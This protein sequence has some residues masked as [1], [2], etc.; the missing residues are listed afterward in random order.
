[1][2]NYCENIMDFY[3]KDIHEVDKMKKLIEDTGVL[4]SNYM[5]E[6]KQYAEGSKEFWNWRANNWGTTPDPTDIEVCYSDSDP[7]EISLI[8]HTAWDSPTKFFDTM[9]DRGWGV[10]G[11]YEGEVLNFIGRYSNKQNVH[12]ENVYSKF[13]AKRLPSWAVEEWG[14]SILD[15]LHS[16]GT[17]DDQCN[18]LNEK[19]KSIRK[20]FG[21]WGYHSIVKKFKEE[22]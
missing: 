17:I 19:D 15:N 16:L 20:P 3:H 4:L 2:P 18:L 5:P 13:I 1:M 7:N 14:Y 11:F 21:E 8:F 6:P 22:L 10:D 9:V 12:V